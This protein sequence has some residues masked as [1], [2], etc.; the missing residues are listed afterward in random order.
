MGAAAAPRRAPLPQPAPLRPRRRPAK[1]RKRPNRALASGART[2][3]RARTAGSARTAGR[4]RAAAPARRAAP[5]RRAVAAA[6]VRPR[7]VA[8]AARLPHAAARTAGAVRDISESSLI[9]RL[10][11]GRGWIALLGAL[12]FGIVVLNVLSLSLNAGN[13]RIGTEIELLERQNSAL[14]AELAE[15]FS[16]SRVEGAA[17]ELGLAV[18]DPQDIRYVNAADSNAEKL[19]KLLGS[20][21]FLASGPTGYPDADTVEPASYAPPEAEVAAAA[22]STPAPSS[23]TPAAP[24]ATTSP[25]PSGGGDGTGGVGL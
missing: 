8:G 21:S 18:P 22:E 10:T 3:T 16:S 15:Q 24:E 11:S 2:A 1:R 19:A 23:S 13:G 7:V 20:E 5:D 17:A 14:R 12:L 4:K 25:A 9:V 6:A